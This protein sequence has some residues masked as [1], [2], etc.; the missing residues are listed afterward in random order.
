MTAT[1]VAAPAS[2]TPD[3]ENYEE[4]SGIEEESEDE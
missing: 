3:A 1:A 4:S 2:A